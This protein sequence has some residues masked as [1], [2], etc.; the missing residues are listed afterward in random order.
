[1]S[2]HFYL[3]FCPFLSLECFK[4]YESNLYAVCYHIPPRHFAEPL[5]PYVPALRSLLDEA[6][7]IPM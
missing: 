7:L 4:T 6:Y 5:E 2:D 3:L 1:M